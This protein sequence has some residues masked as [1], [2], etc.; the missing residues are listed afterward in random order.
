MLVGA[1]QAGASGSTGRTTTHGVLQERVK[2]QCWGPAMHMGTH[3]SSALLTRTWL[4]V[5]CRGL[6]EP[7][8]AGR[9]LSHH[10]GALPVPPWPRG[11][12]S[13]W[14]DEFKGPVTAERSLCLLG[15][16]Q[17]SMSSISCS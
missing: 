5:S 15:H 7:E 3:M 10:N 12:G 1:G 4:A 6:M 2:G 14:G 17:H 11:Q 9:M 16:S 13:K 8:P